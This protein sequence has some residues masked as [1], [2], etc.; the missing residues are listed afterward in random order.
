MSTDPETAVEMLEKFLNTPFK[1][2]CPA[3]D[4]EA[5]PENVQSFLDDT[6]AKMSKIGKNEP[7]S[8]NDNG[9]NNSSCTI[10]ELAK[11]RE[12]SPVGIMPGK[13]IV[14]NLSKSERFEL[15]VGDYLFTAWV[16]S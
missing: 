8:N 13:K 12:F 9:H 5:W 14:W 15:G 2:P 16:V 3:S 6:V 11:G 4:S 10:C 1:S 7:F